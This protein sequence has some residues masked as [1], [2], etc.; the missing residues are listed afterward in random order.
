MM[1]FFSFEYSDPATLARLP[2]SPDHDRYK[3]WRPSG[4]NTGQKCPVSGFSIV[5]SAS[6]APPSADTLNSPFEEP[7]MIVPALLHAPPEKSATALSSLGAP[8][9]MAT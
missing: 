4:R 1:G 9:E 5:V 8:P 7:K 3:Y 6:G 2:A